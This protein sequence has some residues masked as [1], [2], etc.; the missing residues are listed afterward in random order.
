MVEAILVGIGAWLFIYFVL[1][2]ILCAIALPFV[3]L[4][5]FIRD[6]RKYPRIEWLPTDGK[7]W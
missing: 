6:R 7:D 1:P 3:L 4:V 2:S 5:G